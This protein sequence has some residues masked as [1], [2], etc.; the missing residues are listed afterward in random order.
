MSLEESKTVPRRVLTEVFSQG[1]TGLI[2]EIFHNDFTSHTTS[3]KVKGTEGMKTTISM[4][5]G[6]FKDPRFTIEDQVAEGD[7]VATRYTWSGT[8]IGEFMG[9]APTGKQVTFTGIVIY[10]I[11]DGKVIESWDQFDALGMMQQL[12]LVSIPE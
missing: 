3:G 4:N 8:H 1:K 9:A 12:G 5:R 6:A 2:D 10:R 7:K 11:A